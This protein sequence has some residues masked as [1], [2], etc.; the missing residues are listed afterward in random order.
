MA[1]RDLT[2][3]DWRLY[4][5]R[6][7]AWRLFRSMETGQV[8]QAELGPFAAAV[9][10]SVH[11]ALHDAGVIDDWHVGVNSRSAE[12]VEHRHWHYSTAIPAAWIDDAEPLILD[13]QGLDY[14][15][16]IFFDGAEVGRF[17]GTFVPHRFDIRPYVKP[18]VSHRL[19]IVF[20]EPPRE[21]GQ[22]GY[23][24][25][26]RYFK[27][28]YHYGWDWCPRIV[29]VG[30][31]DKLTLR[32]GY[33]AALD[34]LDVRALLHEDNR[35]GRLMMAVVRRGEADVRDVASYEAVLRDGERVVARERAIPG[36]RGA[37]LAMDGIGVE[38]WWPN[39]TSHNP[40]G[41]AKVYELEV[42]ALAASGT[43]LW[44]R[45][46][47]VGFKRVAWEPC[48]GAPDH[49]EPW[50][51]VVNGERL[52]LQGVSWS[53]IRSTFPDTRSQEYQSLVDLYREM[54]CNCLRV[55]G[56]GLLERAPLYEACDRAGL[57]VWQDF[58]LSSSGIDNT[59]PDAPQ[60]IEALTR[61]VETYVRE[62]GHYACRL[63]WCGGNEL[64]EGGVD[65]PPIGYDHPCIAALKAVVDAWDPGRR[66][67][68]TT[69]FGPRFYAHQKDF[70]KGEHHLVHGPW[71]M[72]SFGGL[73]AWKDYWREEDSLF[74][75]EVGMPGAA[76][77]DLIQRYGAGC[78]IWPP[79]SEYWL[80]SSSWWIEWER[81]KSAFDGLDAASALARYV[82]LTQAEQAEALAFAASA[83]KARF[84]R[85]G[86]FLVWHGHDC[87]PCPI[88]NSLIDFERRPKPVF[89]A[90]RT[91]FT[92][93]P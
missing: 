74:R 51:C 42:R 8:L 34:L 87:F 16:W 72:G 54:G 27:P 52:F 53:P 18:G 36:A 11:Q 33:D 28:R 78:D 71:G 23:T 48:E 56:G 9:P 81:L 85:C 4:G 79:T 40:H 29:T 66:F 65:T 2:E 10:G 80:H 44:H 12:W 57:L 30:I 21:Q 89:A 15:G 39:G 20:E 84:P 93:S 47:A 38:P 60:A 68:P 49:A 43:L 22:L 32:S 17:E 59:P 62:H 77:L 6:P 70:G 5:W 55:W 83:C 50:I 76:P 1:I 92:E 3:L 19:D 7:N 67:I 69:P 73:D 26:S 88:N 41:R 75:A 61:M 24:S 13:A 25:K 91:V 90:L 46:L 63:L 37:W 31:W 64:M 58:P 86:G 14:S 35:T 45:R 82:E